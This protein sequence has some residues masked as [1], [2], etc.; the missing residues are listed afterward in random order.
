[1][2]P[3]NILIPLCLADVDRIWITLRH[4]R[5]EFAD[6]TYTHFTAKKE[7][8][9]VTVYEKGPKML[10]QGNGAP[11]FLQDVLEPLIDSAG[12]C[13]EAESHASSLMSCAS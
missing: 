13:P 5:F 4:E 8:L 10:V 12:R 2:D 6:R 7:G 9:H 11:E 3:F 1:M